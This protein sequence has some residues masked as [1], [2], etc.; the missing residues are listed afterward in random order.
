MPTE[1][2]RTTAAARPS[3]RHARWLGPLL[4]LLSGELVVAF[5]SGRSL[6]TA[7]VSLPAF[8]LR[9]AV[10]ATLWWIRLGWL[11]LRARSC[12]VGRV[13][14]CTLLVV[15]LVQV[16]ASGVRLNSVDSISYY[17]FLR[18]MVK[19]HDFNLTNEYAHYGWLERRDLRV[20]T[21]TGHR[22]SIYSVGPAVAW[23]PFF[24][25]GEGVGRAEAWL[26]KAELDLSG[27]GPHHTN[28]VTLGSLL[29]GFAALLLIESLLRRYFARGIATGAVL[30]VWGATFF[31]WYWVVQPN[32]A[33]SAST[34]AAAYAFWLWDRDRSQEV[35]TWSR[36]FLGLILG[37]AMCIRWQNGVLLLLPA[38]DLL[39]RLLRDRRAAGRLIGPAALV[40]A[41]LLIGVLPQ[42]TAWKSLYDMWILPY[43]PQGTDFMRFDHPWV[44]E[45]LFTS[46][47]GLLSWTPVFWLGYLGFVPLLR[48]RF[49][50]GAPLVLP[51]ALMSYVNFCVG[52]Y[53]GGASFSNR[54]FDSLLPVFALGFAAG[55]EA[56]LCSLR[57]RPALGLGALTLPLLVWGILTASESRSDPAASVSLPRL[58]R[59]AG[60]RLAERVGSPRAWPA[61][62]IF[63]WRHAVPAQ[64]YDLLVGRYLFY[65]QGNLD[66]VL[67]L[68]SAEAAPL[69]AEGWS[70]SLMRQGE[71]GRVLASRARVFAPLDVPAALR[72]ELHVLP[73]PDP[74]RLEVSVNGSSLWERTL[75]A[76]ARAVAFEADRKLWRREI[77]EVGL[78]VD[79]PLFVQRIRFTRTEPRS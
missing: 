63:A 11:D 8:G 39:L 64:Q 18:S 4:A 76:R 56:L 48:R 20:P 69:L 6:L 21:R 17:V 65:R 1:A 25:L 72:I 62:W 26:T 67:D 70:A 10:V 12:D 14:L 78:V 47:H 16:R 40:L 22:R 13:L 19:D 23:T 58:V 53:W 66:G 57:R 30:L 60:S 5:V 9:V 38:T 15:A 34:A 74:V 54:R 71:S 59:A 45:T 79:R 50:L 7:E 24:L 28:A 41:G 27:Y 35:T 43:P 73:G 51:L 61:N 31:D 68:G 33:H 52:D 49:G 32:Y 46:R 44:L 3:F 37:L 77:N 75:P 55:I 2:T 42:M 29:Y 36:F